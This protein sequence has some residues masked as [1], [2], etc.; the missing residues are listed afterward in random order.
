MQ[1]KRYR[2]LGARFLSLKHSISFTTWCIWLNSISVTELDVQDR[3]LSRTVQILSTCF[4]GLKA[5][6]SDVDLF[7]SAN[8][9]VMS[10]PIHAPR[11]RQNRVCLA[12]QGRSQCQVSRQVPSS[13]LRKSNI[14]SLKTPEQHVLTIGQVQ[15][16][17][18]LVRQLMK[19]GNPNRSS[20]ASSWINI[21]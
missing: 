6:D 13:K 11:N 4:E 7:E 10:E 8:V 16:L 20:S 18:V 3:W 21:S 15:L 12:G 17:M 5:P 2:H 19:I 1:K 9:S 14:P